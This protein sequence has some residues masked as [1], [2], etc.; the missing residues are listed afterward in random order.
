MLSSPWS[1]RPTL[2]LPQ[3]LAVQSLQP[4]LELVGRA[5]EIR[6]VQVG[7][8]LAGVVTDLQHVPLEGMQPLQVWGQVRQL[9]PAANFSK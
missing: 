9:L 3:G 1:V 8:I 2:H 7:C 5:D 6:I 4:G